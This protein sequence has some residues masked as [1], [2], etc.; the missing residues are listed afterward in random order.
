M[1]LINTREPLA[2]L[3]QR[4]RECRIARGDTQAL[5]ADRIGCSAVTVRAMEKGDPTVGIGQWVKAFWILDRLPEL[6]GLLRQSSLF[7]DFTGRKRQRKRR[8]A[9]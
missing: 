6:D 1:E 4:L 9:A 3:G 5:F 8:G 7:E 2:S